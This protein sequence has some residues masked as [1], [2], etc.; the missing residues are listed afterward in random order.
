MLI[1][2]A[3]KWELARVQGPELRNNEYKRNHHD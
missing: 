3:A 2:S 1:I